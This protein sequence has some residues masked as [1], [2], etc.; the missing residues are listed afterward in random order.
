MKIKL[1]ALFS[2]IGIMQISV[3]CHANT[4][5]TEMEQVFNYQLKYVMATDD[6]C[7]GA[8]DYYIMTYNMNN[9]WS[10]AVYITDP[11]F[12]IGGLSVKDGYLY[13][14][15]NN[16]SEGRR[17]VLRSSDGENWEMLYS[18]N[19]SQ[20]GGFYENDNGDIT[21]PLPNSATVPGILDSGTY[22]DPVNDYEVEF[23]GEKISL[24][25][26]DE[27]YSISNIGRHKN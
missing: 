15:T 26:T 20:T 10:D 23:N 14:V 16:M 8:T 27:A 18:F 6:I 11:G 3:I 22:D 2:V 13:A 19:S 21:L 9:D 12:K 1:L 25:D 24:A 17:Q 4:L 7:I 5:F